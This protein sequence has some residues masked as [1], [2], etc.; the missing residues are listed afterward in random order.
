V[1]SFSYRSA[2]NG[3]LVAGL[4]LVI[5]IETLVL[6]LWLTKS[7]PII[8]WTLTVSSLAAIGWLVADYRAL[9][10]GA[11]QLTDERL[12]LRVGRRFDVSVPTTAV[13]SALRPTW[14]DLPNP[15]TPQAADYLNLTKPAAPNVLLI[16]STPMDVRLP[17]GL[18]RSATRLALCLDE[19]D[20]FLAAIHPTPIS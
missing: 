4:G 9:G 2:R 10:R 12:A 20:E 13:S 17:G 16:L 1:T 15:G 18:R 14:R 5:A 19:P 11:V 7:H 3:S 8:G 6:H